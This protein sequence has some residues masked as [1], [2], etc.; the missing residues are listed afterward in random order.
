[1]PEELASHCPAPAGISR[2][3][4]QGI[5]PRKNEQQLTS[6]TNWR[7][8]LA[9]LMATVQV[10]LRKPRTSDEYRSTLKQCVE[11]GSHMTMLVERLLVLS[12]LDSGVDPVRKEP[13]NIVELAGQCVDMLRPLADQRQISIEMEVDDSANMLESQPTDAA[14]LREILVNLID[15]GVHY[16]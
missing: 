6:L 3:A 8:P 16:N 15:N 2:I 10:A 7:T 14:K 5:C 13:V 4:G 1:M 12:R 11:T 9:S